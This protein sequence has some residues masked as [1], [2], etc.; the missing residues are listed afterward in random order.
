MFVKLSHVLS[1]EPDCRLV[2]ILGASESTSVDSI[3][4]VGV[5]P[6]I[7]FRH[8]FMQAFGREVKLRLLGEV[9]EFAV[10]HLDDVRRLV[11]D[12]CLLLLVPQNW[13]R[14]SSE[15]IAC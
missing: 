15:G 12:H 1:V 14:I 4:D 5:D 7:D 8:S 9:I 2:G 11:A 13:H 10:Q 3:V 6:A